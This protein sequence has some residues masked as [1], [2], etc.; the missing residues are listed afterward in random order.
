M[1]LNVDFNTYTRTN[2]AEY[3]ERP[4]ADMYPGEAMD[5]FTL[6]NGALVVTRPGQMES[7]DIDHCICALNL[8]LSA[9]Y[10]LQAAALTKAPRVEGEPP[11]DLAASRPKEPQVDTTLPPYM[12]GV[13]W[14]ATDGHVPAPM[15]LYNERPKE[16]QVVQPP[17]FDAYC[18][19]VDPDQ[20]SP[21]DQPAPKKRF[22]A[23]VH[24][25]NPALEDR[26]DDIPF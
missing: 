20:E 19:P 22:P 15:P 10:R 4:P 14:P 24:P 17:P 13:D 18:L 9:M 8:V 3:C 6:S 26:S 16:P 21:K 5:R 12:V 25:V 1:S 7:G 23:T 2:L 11:T